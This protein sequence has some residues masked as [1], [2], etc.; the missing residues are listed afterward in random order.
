M[1]QHVPPGKTIDDPA[2]ASAIGTQIEIASGVSM[3]PL[4]QEPEDFPEAA[5]R[6]ALRN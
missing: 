2:A 3:Q 6:I 1:L 5:V 4:A